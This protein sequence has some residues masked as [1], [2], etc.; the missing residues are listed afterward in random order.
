MVADILNGLPFPDESFDVIVSIHVLPEIP[1]RS[2]PAALS[3]LRRILCPGGV[4]RLALPDMNKAI[5][6]YRNDDV[7]YLFLIP[8]EEAYSNSS[9]FASAPTTQSFGNELPTWNGHWGCLRFISLAKTT[10]ALTSPS[11]IPG[12]VRFASGWRILPAFEPLNFDLI[13]KFGDITS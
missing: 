12:V 7:D 11:A 10:K 4:L 2:L 5:Q 3:E 13:S 9:T 1:Y 8:D 6:A